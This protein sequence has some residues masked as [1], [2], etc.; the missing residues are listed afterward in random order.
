MADRAVQV[1]SASAGVP[2]G[3]ALW[4]GDGVVGAVSVGRAVSDPVPA[5]PPTATTPS[6]ARTALRDI[7]VV[8]H[9][10]VLSRHKTLRR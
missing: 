4:V 3:V 1:R 7:V 2:V 8:I 6:V 10:P 9:N 5:H